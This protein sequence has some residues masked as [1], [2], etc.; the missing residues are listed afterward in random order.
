MTETTV[1][2]QTFPPLETPS[3]KRLYFG[4]LMFPIP[5]PP[6]TDASSAFIAYAAV[7]LELV[8]GKGVQGVG[9]MLGFCDA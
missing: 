6:G 2:T 5:L 4:P 8:W 1:Y 7:K 3:G 9:K